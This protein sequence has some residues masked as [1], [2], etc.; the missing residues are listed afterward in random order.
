MIKERFFD[1]MAPMDHEGVMYN[2]PRPLPFY[3]DN[4]AWHM[5]YHR[6]ML[7]KVPE[8][9][10]LHQFIVAMNE[11]GNLSRQEA[12]S[13]IP[14]LLLDVKPEHAVLDMCAAPG[15]KTAQIIEMLHAGGEPYPKGIVIANDSDNKRCYTLTHQ[16]KRLQSPNAM[17]VNHD[18]SMFPKIKLTS[19]ADLEFDRILCD[20]PCC[21]DG[22]LRKNPNAWTKWSPMNG[23]GLH[24][25]Q[26]KI[27]FRGIQLLKV[28]GRLVYST[29]TFNPI[30]NEAVVAEL[31]R[32]SGGNLELVDVSKEL[33]NL[34]RVPGVTDWKVMS[35]EGDW[36]PAEH[37]KI[38]ADQKKQFKAS[39]W[40]PT[41]EETASLNL[42]RCVRVFPQLQD[43][44][45][46]FI[47][48]F[49]KLGPIKQSALEKPQPLK[50]NTRGI[51][52]WDAVEGRARGS[53]GGTGQG[54]GGGA[55]A[56]GGK[57]KFGGGFKEDPYIFQ[58]QDTP[59]FAPLK[60]FYGIADTFPADQLVTRSAQAKKRHIYFVSGLAKEVLVNNGNDRLRTINVGVKVLTRSDARNAPVDYRLCMDGIE[61]LAPSMTKRVAAISHTDI[62]LVVGSTD[63]TK[64][65]ELSEVGKASAA[66]VSNG[67]TVLSYVPSEDR[68]AGTLSCPINII[69]WKTPTHFK[70]LVSK[71][72][73]NMLRLLLGIDYEEAPKKGRQGQVAATFKGV[74]PA[75]N[76]SPTNQLYAPSA[77][78][79]AAAAAAAAATK[80][81]GGGGAAAAA[82]GGSKAK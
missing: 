1:K 38:T 52:F 16:I 40:P 42:D 2:P 66:D 45:G 26:V 60:E 6:T 79:A 32:M 69:A 19:G 77:L 80:G 70:P 8:L 13:M 47:A 11:K 49:N 10:K 30:Q 63:G 82:G 14:P 25:L 12:V 71:D 5:D 62:P 76:Y 36:L 23:V 28:G 27:A 21:G 81:G 65:T 41:A 51:P 3:P 64:L 56:E 24:K 72:E 22:T 33:P 18:A 4:L 34:K 17:V 15:S 67:C 35:K 39:M 57:K 29:C 61:C 53:Y 55:A 46:F 50:V 20:V 68:P 44:G 74:K 48:V 75:A 9:K 58:E 37:D 43:T 59:Y 73:R 31:L 54:K 7:R 78:A